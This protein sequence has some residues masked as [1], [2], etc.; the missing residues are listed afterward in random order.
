MDKVVYYNSLFLLYKNLLTINE[1]EIFSLYYEENYS[2]GEIAQM[3]GI[4]RSAVGKYVSTTEKKLDGYEKILRINE[5]NDVL[6]KLLDEN[7]INVIKDGI[8][9]IL[10]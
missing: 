6:S 1:Q 2:M 9:S 5:K 3:K 10:D 4:T 7:D 8:Q